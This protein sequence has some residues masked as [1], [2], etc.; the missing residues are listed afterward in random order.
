MRS[1]SNAAAATAE[2]K[3]KDVISVTV[4]GTGKVVKADNGIRVSTMD[5]MV[6]A[7]VISVTCV[8]PSPPSIV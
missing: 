1:H 3:L 7:S 8:K 2:G 4:P 6:R 5:K